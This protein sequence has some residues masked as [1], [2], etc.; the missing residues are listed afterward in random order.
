MA[1]CRSCR[2][3]A[4][5]HPGIGE[6]LEVRASRLDVGGDLGAEGGPG[7]GHAAVDDE[8]QPLTTR[9]L[10]RAHHVLARLVVDGER[11]LGE[12]DR[13]L[14]GD[15]DALDHGVA[16]HGPDQPPVC[17]DRRPAS[18]SRRAVSSAE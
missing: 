11:A 4:G 15:G 14:E 1:A 16:H 5:H 8:E 17:A 2:P 3:A 13:V 18:S 12:D 9:R 7:G 10:A 6:Q